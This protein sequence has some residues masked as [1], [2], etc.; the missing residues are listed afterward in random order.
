[1]ESFFGVDFGGVRIHTDI[2]AHALNRALNARAFTT[3][4]DIFF[5]HQEY[6]SDIAHSREL[7]AHELAHVVQ[8]DGRVHLPLNIARPDGDLERDADQA[9]RV[10][11]TWAEWTKQSYEIQQQSGGQAPAVGEP[12]HATTFGLNA[13]VSGVQRQGP[14]EIAGA[15]FEAV[16]TAAAVAPSG[17]GGLDLV[18]VRFRYARTTP[19]PF[20]PDVVFEREYSILSL[21]TFKSFGTSHVWI[22]LIL[23]FDGVNIIGAYTRETIVQGYEGNWLGSEAGVEFS[24]VK[25]SE[26]KAPIAEAYLLFNGFNN[27]TG[28]GFQRFTGR[29][30]VAG[31]G[32]VRADVEQ[33]FLTQG[34]GYVRVNSARSGFEIGWD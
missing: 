15:V 28:P 11:K 26:E 10:F 19:G 21:S 33:T 12:I 31:S 4:Q 3:G 24:A 1:M 16:Q 6:A 32:E 30:R 23:R 29:I 20:G 8:Q 9:S 5:R 2:E 13:D 25:I 34:D 27:P 17:A 18:N 7:I 14:V 22:D